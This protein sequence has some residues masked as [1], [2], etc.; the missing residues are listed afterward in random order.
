[1]RKQVTFKNDNVGEIMDRL[2]P[3]YVRYNYIYIILSF[4]IIIQIQRMKFVLIATIL[5]GEARRPKHFPPL[6][7]NT[8]YFY[9]PYLSART[10]QNIIFV[11]KEDR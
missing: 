9:L 7:I 2:K 10:N 6:D 3:P 1:M 11:L 4:L 8:T 5:V